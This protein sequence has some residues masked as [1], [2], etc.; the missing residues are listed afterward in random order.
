MD[1]FLLGEEQGV[2]VMGLD[3]LIL[4]TN[5]INNDNSNE[6]F[7]KQGFPAN[8]PSC[9]SMLGWVGRKKES[10]TGPW[11]NWGTEMDVCRHRAGPHHGVLSWNP[12]DARKEGLPAAPFHRWAN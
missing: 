12:L 11:K 4:I 2:Q 6:C 9:P 8:F 3:H 5:N 1:L 7:M 10:K